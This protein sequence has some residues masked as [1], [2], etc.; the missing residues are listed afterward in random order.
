[1]CDRSPLP[2]PFENVDGIIQRKIL[3]RFEISRPSVSQELVSLKKKE[4]NVMGYG[5]HS[6]LTVIYRELYVQGG[7]PKR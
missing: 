7:V 5:R 4:V 3:R 1:M 6:W 2:W